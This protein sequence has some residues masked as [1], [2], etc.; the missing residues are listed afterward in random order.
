MLPSSRDILVQGDKHAGHVDITPAK[1][2][3]DSEPHQDEGA[4]SAGAASDA[5]AHM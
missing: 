2:S 4:H 3:P 1:Q 5:R